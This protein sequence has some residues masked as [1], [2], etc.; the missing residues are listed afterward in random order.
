MKNSRSYP[1]FRRRRREGERAQRCSGESMRGACIGGNVRR[2]RLTPALLRSPTLSAS[3]KEGSCSFSNVSNSQNFKP[4][5]GQT[6]CF[7]N[8]AW[9]SS[10]AGNTTQKKTQAWAT[11]LFC[12][13][14]PPLSFNVFSNKTS[15]PCIIK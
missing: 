4:A 6:I 5:I 7:I 1:P 3:G 10:G 14:L 9:N 13:N 12:R 8:S 11:S 15:A 2:G